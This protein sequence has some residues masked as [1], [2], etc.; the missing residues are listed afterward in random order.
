ML[1][2]FPL[3]A[4]VLSVWAAEDKSSYRGA[5][6]LR[7]I[8]ALT[9]SAARLQGHPEAVINTQHPSHATSAAGSDS[10]TEAAASEGCRRGQHG[11]GGTCAAGCGWKVPASRHGAEPPSVREPWLCPWALVG[12]GYTVSRTPW[13]DTGCAY[14][15]IVLFPDRGWHSAPARELLQLLGPGGSLTRPASGRTGSGRIA[16]IFCLQS[17]SWSDG[18][19]SPGPAASGGVRSCARYFSTRRG[20]GSAPP[21]PPPGLGLGAPAAPAGLVCPSLCTP[22]VRGDLDWKPERSL[23]WV[24]VGATAAP[25]DPPFPFQDPQAEAEAAPRTRRF[26]GR[27]QEASLIWPWDSG[28]GFHSAELFANNVSN[29]LDKKGL[30]FWCQL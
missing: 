6:P 17:P 5:Q 18:R 12:A 8:S 16:R 21:R 10:A 19:D 13:G 30:C 7:G 23:L 2:K 9:A 27:L 25:C 4:P 20:A 26:A 28:S 1:W 15:Q 22:L 3:S 24:S 14:V 11:A 29:V